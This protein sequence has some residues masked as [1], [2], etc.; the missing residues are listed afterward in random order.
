MITANGLS[1]E[2][3]L[4]EAANGY[5]TLRESIAS[6]FTNAMN[7]F[8][9]LE[10]RR[11]RSTSSSAKKR[12]WALKDISFDV[13][14]GEIVGVI[15]QNGAGKSTL[16][17]VLSRITE[18]T[19]GVIKIQGRLATLLEVGT[20]FH[21][22]LTGRE[23]IFLNGAVLGMS[24][25][26][27]RRNFDAIVDFAEIEGFLDTPVKRY[28]SGMYVRLA[29]AV[30]SHLQ[31]EILIVDEVL[32]VGDAR[33]QQKCLGRMSEVS[34]SGRTI[35]FVSH[36]MSAIKSLCTRALVLDGGS[37]I[38]DGTVD[39]GVSHYFSSVEFGR[40]KREIADGYPRMTNDEAR[41]RSV[42][43]SSVD[44]N[45]SSQFYFGDPI[46]VRFTCEI[47][48]DIPDGHFEVS[49]S[50]A[51]GIHVLYSTSIDGGRPAKFLARGVHEVGLLIDAHLLPNRYS[52]DLG[53][54][55]QNGTTA[56]FVQRTID[57]VVLRVAA[58]G[59]DDYRWGTVRGLVRPSAEWKYVNDHKRLIDARVE[60]SFLSQQAESCERS[61]GAS[62]AK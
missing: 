2:Y 38:H 11:I 13:A 61:I 27:I 36:N 53:V 9:Q 24:R 50:T 58:K 30:A 8:K 21:P 46:A 48:A 12:F 51:D 26:E 32:A 16:L 6:A 49:V 31:P 5:Q 3:R 7:P 60:T 39:D 47:L 56:D 22:E 14:P 62:G 52:I 45:P 42:E 55:H 34:R 40:T 17:K 57:F 44:G 28:S 54:H 25:S 4:G 41:F 59:Q 23:N 35:L 19:A 20:G 15:G 18:P 1:K 10:K 33:F 29:F 43:I 37:L